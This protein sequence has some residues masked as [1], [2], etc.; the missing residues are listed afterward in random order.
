M[1]LTKVIAGGLMCGLLLCFSSCINEDYSLDKEIDMTV[2]VGQNV[3]LPIGRVDTIWL[4]QII[5][6]DD[7]ELLGETTDGRYV[8]KESGEVS[9]TIGGVDEIVINEF[10]T[11]LEPYSRGFNV[12]EELLP[13]GFDIET[14]PNDYVDI[15]DMA[16]DVDASLPEEQGAFNVQFALPE[17]IESI[18]YV[19]FTDGDKKDVQ[20][21]FGLELS[22]IPSFVHELQLKDAVIGLPSVLDF[23]IEEV[24]TETLKYGKNDNNGIDIPLA[25]IPVTKGKAKILLTFTLHGIA[26]PVINE[27]GNVVLDDHLTFHSIFHVE[28]HDL[29]IPIEDFKKIYEDDIWVNIQPHFKL[30]APLLVSEVAGKMIPDFDLSSNISLADIPEFLKE[31]NTLIDLK[32]FSLKLDVTNPVGVP[33]RAELALYER[34]EQYNNIGEPVKL[35]FKVEPLT[36]TELKIS[37]SC[38]YVLSGS[39][40]DLLSTIPANLYLEVT[41]LVIESENHEQR[42]LLEGKDVEYQFNVAYDL[43]V[44]M[45]FDNLHISYSD[46]VVGLQQE[47]SEVTEWIDCLDLCVKIKHTI[48]MDIRLK[49]TPY[50]AEGNPIE[51]LVF[52]ESITVGAAPCPETTLD[53]E[54]GSRLEEKVSELEIRL[55]ETRDGALKELDQLYIVAEGENAEGQGVVLRPDQYILLSLSARL[56]KGITVDLNELK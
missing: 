55:S 28:E 13:P 25:V 46:T 44:P 56:P 38:E 3:S 45:E 26:N 8:V 10:E 30:P 15:A 50:N 2:Q 34:D 11:E 37:E 4:N 17:E 7:E 5:V 52:P 51:G 1:N 43:E 47:L 27:E 18:S 33:I 16:F 20:V 12:K 42:L 54:S 49:I 6:T 35:A 21:Q 23:E 48:P 53:N 40:T 32:D 31:E 36:T 29:H 19:K 14:L 39:L 24:D 22:N 41:E 9:E